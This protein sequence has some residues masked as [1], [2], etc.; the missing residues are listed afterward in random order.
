MAKWH[1]MQ[2][3]LTCSC[4]HT[5]HFVKQKCV[6]YSGII[7]TETLL[8]LYKYRTFCKLKKGFTFLSPQLI[9]SSSF[10][11]LKRIHFY[12]FRERKMTA[13]CNYPEINSRKGLMS[14]TTAAQ[15]KQL[16]VFSCS[17]GN[18]SRKNTIEN[19]TSVIKIMLEN[20]R[21]QVLHS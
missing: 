10:Q 9:S 13:H 11:L 15:M 6:F 1:A 18:L 3:S 19:S 4:K 21:Q 16:P 12:V 17:K 2:T 14:L 8:K 20:K 5:R 7:D